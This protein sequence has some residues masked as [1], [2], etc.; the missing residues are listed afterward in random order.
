VIAPE[1]QQ[2]VL[3]LEADTGMPVTDS[4]IKLSLSVASKN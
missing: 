3:T 1:T 2:N 4:T